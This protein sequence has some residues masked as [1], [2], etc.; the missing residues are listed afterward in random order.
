MFSKHKFPIDDSATLFSPDCVSSTSAS[1][2]VS[3]SC[4]K[5]SQLSARPHAPSKQNEYEE[6]INISILSTN[7]ID[8]QMR[9]NS[10][11]Q[12]SVLATEPL[13]VTSPSGLSNPSLLSDVLLLSSD[14]ISI[15]SPVQSSSNVC[16]SSN[17]L[18]LSSPSDVDDPTFP[19]EDRHSATMAALQ[20][21][22]DA[23]F[24][25]LVSLLQDFLQEL[26]A[27]S[28][29]SPPP[30]QISSLSPEARPTTQEIQGVQSLSPIAINNSNV[31]NTTNHTNINTNLNNITTNNYS[32]NIDSTSTTTS[33]TTTTNNNT[34]IKN[35]T[36][37]ATINTTPNTAASNNNTNTNSTST[38]ITN[39]KN[40]D[41]ANNTTTNNI[42]SA[43]S[44]IKSAK[45]SKRKAKVAAAAPPLPPCLSSQADFPPLSSSASPMS[46]DDSLAPTQSFT[47]SNSWTHSPAVVHSSII[48]ASLPLV[49]EVSLVNYS[50]PIEPLSSPSMMS[51]ESQLSEILAVLQQPSS[52]PL[53]L[54]WVEDLS[55]IHQHCIDSGDPE[56]LTILQ[57]ELDKLK[58][59][60]LTKS[61]ILSNPEF[62]A[63]I[64]KLQSNHQNCSTWP[65][66]RSLFEYLAALQLLADDQSRNLFSQ[67]IYAFSLHQTSKSKETWE[68]LISSQH[69]ASRQ[70]Y[71]SRVDCGQSSNQSPLSPLAILAPAP[72]QFPTPSQATPS[73]ESLTTSSDSVDNLLQPA[74]QRA[75]KTKRRKG[76]N[77]KDSSVI[78][79]LIKPPNLLPESALRDVPSFPL[80]LDTLSSPLSSPIERAWATAL[81]AHGLQLEPDAALSYYQSV[82]RALLAYFDQKR[83][84]YSTEL[85]L[86]IDPID[87]S[88][89]QSWV[90]ILAALLRHPCV[91]VY[92]QCLADE[93]VFLYSY[94]QT[95]GSDE[96]ADQLESKFRLVGEY[97]CCRSE[98][99]RVPLSTFSY[100]TVPLDSTDMSSPVKYTEDYHSASDDK[101]FS[102]LMSSISSVAS[103]S[104]PTSVTQPL[105]PVAI[106][107]SPQQQSP[108]DSPYS[109]EE[110]M[111][112]YYE[113]DDDDSVEDSFL[114]DDYFFSLDLEPGADDSLSLL[115]TLPLSSEESSSCTEEMNSVPEVPLSSVVVASPS[116]PPQSTHVVD[117]GGGGVISTP[118]CTPPLVGICSPPPPAAFVAA[119][120]EGWKSSNLISDDYTPVDDFSSPPPPVTVE[121]AW[122]EGWKSLTLSLYLFLSS[123]S[124]AAIS[125]PP[126]PVTPEVAW[127]EG[128]KPF[129]NTSSSPSVLSTVT[130]SHPKSRARRLALSTSPLLLV[131]L[132]LNVIFFLNVCTL[133]VFPPDVSSNVLRSEPVSLAPG[134]SEVGRVLPLS[135][136]DAP[137]RTLA[138]TPWC[139][140][141]LLFQLFPWRTVPCPLSA[142]GR[143]LDK[144]S[145]S[146]ISLFS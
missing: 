66:P 65:H 85:F 105:S 94:S 49:H 11:L 134:S 23:S 132:L 35:S 71:Y 51:L 14:S 112:V 5:S 91:D 100:P 137:S 98:S 54:L 55:D 36:N 58:C 81:E 96:V 8:V 41:N 120:W 118:V 69:D 26:R 21:S 74:S 28:P 13:Y 40:D 32:N 24:A 29:S 7:S 108:P 110:E 30:T 128:W 45:K 86:L 106:S 92:E 144:S 124:L 47:L 42:S 76:K 19:W 145:I 68:Y 87:D 146:S 121:V 15:T 22:T 31:K 27:S 139:S 111:P 48:S 107:S 141:S 57:E 50:Q 116:P 75:K 133:Y 129:S 18:G 113:E 136:P 138:E 17:S 9:S 143:D 126:P 6:S 142:L 127:W 3:P 88:H 2:K 99:S 93:I 56:G 46:P 73:S 39:N 117:R 20:A 1:T 130:S 59:Y 114:F 38:T 25:A 89:Y 84:L 70:I 79:S 135:I 53:E 61:S 102:P 43:R 80:L 72:P 16:C 10:N 83:Q 82:G 140:L 60:F 52:S 122:W 119:W 109:P 67:C 90:Q 104:S 12:S 4:A 115:S 63:I 64:I 78:L 125:S 33:S 101:S 34:N 123:F 37:Y 62:T 77:S 131:S 44:S 103:T 97:L 95:T